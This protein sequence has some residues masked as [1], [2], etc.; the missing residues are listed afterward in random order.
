[1]YYLIILDCAIIKIKI[2]NK[3]NKVNYGAVWNIL[4]IVFIRIIIK[5]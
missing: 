2:K 4:I 1:M 3:T 5:Y